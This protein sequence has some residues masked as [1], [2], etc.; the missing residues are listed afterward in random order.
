MASST[1]ENY[2]KHLYTA[3]LAA[4]E[5]KVATGKL[6]ESL[7][8][9][10]GTAT[11]MVKALTNAGLVEY[12]PR[13]GVRLTG[14][15]EEL[16]LH[17]LRRHRLV[18]LFLVRTLGLDWSEVHDEAEELEHAISDKVLERIDELLDHP[19]VDPHGDPIPSARGTLERPRSASLA[20]CATGTPLTVTRIVDQDPRFLRFAEAKQLKPGTRL[21]VESRDP[22]A[23]AVTLAPEGNAPFT[24]GA[25]AAAKVLVDPGEAQ[26]GPDAG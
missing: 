26:S 12:E 2:L 14:R 9:A 3:Q 6:A 23:D 21:T 7:D 18:E 5:G 24:I 20:D 17:V 1:V 11:S 15:G 19:T 8:V 13:D 10:P 16:A 25:A 22:V 4:G